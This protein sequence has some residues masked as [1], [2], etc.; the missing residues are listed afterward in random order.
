MTSSEEQRNNEQFRAKPDS[1][2]KVMEQPLLNEIGR[3]KTMY[4]ITD[5]GIL[6]IAPT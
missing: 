3:G 1:N 4:P 6:A 5:S 2:P